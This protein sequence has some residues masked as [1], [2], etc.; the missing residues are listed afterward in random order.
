V[1]LTRNIL[2]LALHGKIPLEAVRPSHS[3]LAQTAQAW[4]NTPFGGKGLVEDVREKPARILLLEK[5]GN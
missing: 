3:C 4:S 5:I 1:P 2:F